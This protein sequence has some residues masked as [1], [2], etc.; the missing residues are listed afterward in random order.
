M[1]KYSK[2]INIS[3]LLI[4][5]ITL[6]AYL[7]V[8]NN[9]VSIPSTFPNSFLDIVIDKVKLQFNAQGNVVYLS[10]SLQKSLEIAVINQQFVT[11]AFINWNR[12]PSPNGATTLIPPYDCTQIILRFPM[13]YGRINEDLK[14]GDPNGPSLFCK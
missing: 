11:D 13:N 10:D 12:I 6:I 9:V 5:P 7:F 2:L 1:I 4:V 14:I 3:F 8:N